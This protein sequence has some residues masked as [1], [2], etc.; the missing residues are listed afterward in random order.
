VLV[1]ALKSRFRFFVSLPCLERFLD[2]GELMKK[3]VYVAIFV[4][5]ASQSSA[6]AAIIY[7][8]FNGS[9]VMYLDVTES[10]SAD[11]PKFNAPEVFGNQLDFGPTGF[12]TQSGGPPVTQQSEL[13]L[14]VM[15]DVTPITQLRFEESG[16][17]TL[18]GLAGTQAEASVVAN[19]QVTVTEVG[20][21]A[22]SP[23]CTDTGVFVFSANP[24]GVFTLPNDRGT[25]K[26]WSGSLDYDV[27]AL[28]ASCGV[29]GHATK[30]DLVLD[31]TLT[32]SAANGGAAFIAK[33][34]LRVSS[35]VTVPEPASVGLLF[36][37]MA[38]FGFSRRR[39]AS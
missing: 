14:T 31:N 21:Q 18:S 23:V 16:D 29:T 7:G 24:S 25:S 12:V 34:D 15:S 17:Y 20:G 26:A 35:I 19:V 13:S 39:S 5:V 9:T 33:K 30:I 37:A 22:L 6:L 2:S 4:L 1:E 28:L 36:V 3:T 11:T 10:N 38:G 32:A 8:D 27:D